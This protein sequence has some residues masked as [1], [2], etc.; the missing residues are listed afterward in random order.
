[1]LGKIVDK[2]GVVGYVFLGA[3]ELEERGAISVLNAVKKALVTNFGNSGLTLL[4]RISSVVTDG[5]S[6][7]IGE[8]NGIWTLLESKRKSI[9][10]VKSSQSIPLVKVWCAVHRS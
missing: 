6:I 2:F 10:S 7:S 8:K 4:Q 3:A 9:K 1:V 5:A